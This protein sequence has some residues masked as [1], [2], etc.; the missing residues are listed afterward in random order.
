LRWRLPLL[1]ELRRHLRRGE[2]HL[3]RCHWRLAS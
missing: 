1:C 3:W 2:H